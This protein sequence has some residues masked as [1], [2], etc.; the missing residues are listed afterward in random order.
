M[1]LDNEQYNKYFILSW[2]YPILLFYFIF[3]ELG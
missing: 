1:K 2:V 3:E